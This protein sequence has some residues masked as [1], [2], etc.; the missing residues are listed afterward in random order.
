M[1]E[2]KKKEGRFLCHIYEIP[3]AKEA[4]KAIDATCVR[5]YGSVWCRRTEIGRCRRR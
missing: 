2:G 1:S 3:D 4:Y 5:E